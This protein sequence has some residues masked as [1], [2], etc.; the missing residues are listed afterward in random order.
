VSRFVLVV[1][2]PV[3]RARVENRVS[4]EEG[5]GVYWEGAIVYNYLYNAK[6][7]P[8][9]IP[10]LLDDDPESSVPMPLDG[11]TRYRLRAFELSDPGFEALYRE[12]TAQPEITKPALGDVVKLNVRGA[13]RVAGALP[14]KKAVTDFPSTDD[15]GTTAHEPGPDDG[16]TEATAALCGSFWSPFS[17]EES[18]ARGEIRFWAIVETVLAIAVFWWIAIRWEKFTLLTTSLFV[19]PL[20]LLRSEERH[21]NMV[22]NLF[23]F[24]SWTTWMAGTSP[25][26]T[27]KGRI[28]SGVHF[29]RPCVFVLLKIRISATVAP[30]GN[31]F[32]GLLRASRRRLAGNPG[33][34]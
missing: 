11:H 13:I 30:M 15:D 7:N 26:M 20:L 23:H 29:F 16:E 6:A 17:D 2:T 1:C 5:R 21:G 27:A 8:R 3:Y 33:A 28:A 18:V 24:L 14:A 10:V 32:P 31:L 19:V 34:A 4:A 25:A 22:A 12:L 9:F